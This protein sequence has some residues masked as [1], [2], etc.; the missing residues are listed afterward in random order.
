[1]H[2][3]LHEVLFLD[4]QAWQH[5]WAQKIAVGFTILRVGLM[6]AMRGG[7][8]V[9][10]GPPAAFAQHGREDT[11]SCMLSSRQCVCQHRQE[12]RCGKQFG[13]DVEICL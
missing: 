5:C 3:C 9:N 13:Q 12:D 6:V 7:S 1:M 2:D 4:V 10:V 8:G 11:H